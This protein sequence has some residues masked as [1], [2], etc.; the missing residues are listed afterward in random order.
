MEDAISMLSLRRRRFQ[1]DQDTLGL[2]G[3]CEK[4]ELRVGAA[5]RHH[6]QVHE[7]GC[8]G[9]SW[10]SARRDSLSP[11]RLLHSFNYFSVILTYVFTIQVPRALWYFSCHSRNDAENTMF[12]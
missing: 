6:G 3:G 8:D 4:W 2:S 12:G 5:L 1:Q 11:E 9:I 7:V 10:W